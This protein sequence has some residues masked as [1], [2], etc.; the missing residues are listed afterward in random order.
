M[1]DMAITTPFEAQ[2][3]PVGLALALGAAALLMFLG[4]V[5]LAAMVAGHGE[6]ITQLGP[7]MGLIG[8]LIPLDALDPTTRAILAALCQSDIGARDPLSSLP[9][10]LAM[11]TA[12]S[13]AMMIPTALPMLMASEGANIDR[14][15]VLGGYVT[16]WFAFSALAATLQVGLA[17]AGLMDARTM[18]ALSDL[19][20][21]AVLIGAGLYQF[22]ALKTLCVTQ[23]QVPH[24]VYDI[25][26][27]RGEGPFASGLR[28]GFLCVGC[29]WALM[30]VSLAMGVMNLVWMAFASA[31]MLIEKSMATTRFSKAIGLVLIMAGG[32]M[33]AGAVISR[34]PH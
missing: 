22:S 26:A 6:E 2:A 9:I 28:Q 33:V 17:T 1:K 21:G 15:K 30:L 18:I 3:K 34:W 23:C 24:L 5:L 16:V 20:G 4:W 27:R 10:V 29:C 31:I 19:F 8:K 14:L 32:V 11:W 13:L 25:A 7:A 12:M